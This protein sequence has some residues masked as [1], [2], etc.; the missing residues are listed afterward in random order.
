MNQPVSRSIGD[1][2][3]EARRPRLA[4]IAVALAMLCTLAG[5][6]GQAGDPCWSDLE[7]SSGSCSFGTCDSD[8]VAL[9]GFTVQI[10]AAASDSSAPRESTPPRQS[11]DT[12]SSYPD[13]TSL[14][15]TTCERTL[16][17][18]Y[19]SYCVPASDCSWEADAGNPCYA[20]FDP[21]CPSQCLLFAGCR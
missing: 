5:C 21:S 16:G 14:D 8:L 13:C 10:I 11:T 18:H 9:I 17:C 6:E 2:R 15:E 19:S 20:C 3:R 7:C 1:P 4:A 12:P